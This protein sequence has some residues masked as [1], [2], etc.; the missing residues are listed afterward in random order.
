MRL[1]PDAVAESS[2]SATSTPTPCGVIYPPMAARQ[3]TWLLLV[4]TVRGWL[5]IDSLGQIVKRTPPALRL[6]RLAFRDQ[7]RRLPVMAIRDGG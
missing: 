7:A 2:R 1:N 3:R 6:R 5:L 4:Q